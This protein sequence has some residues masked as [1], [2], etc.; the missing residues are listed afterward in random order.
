[1]AGTSILAVCLNQWGD[2][3]ETPETQQILDGTFDL[4]QVNKWTEYPH[5]AIHKTFL[6][7]LQQPQDKTGN[8]IPDMPWSYGNK[9]F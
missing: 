3:A 7:N 5:K 9:V 4:K 1:M 8:N 6:K 2:L